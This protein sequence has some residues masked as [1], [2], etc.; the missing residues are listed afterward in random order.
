MEMYSNPFI[1][2]C[3]AIL[4]LV[5]PLMSFAQTAQQSP[6]P[7]QQKYP[8]PFSKSINQ[9]DRDLKVCK[10][11]YLSFKKSREVSYLK[12]AETYC[13][14]AIKMLKATQAVYPNTTRFFYK[15]K[16][17]RLTACKFF[18]ELQETAS[19]LDPLHHIKDVADNGCSF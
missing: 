5:F 3:L 13:S 8:V 9:S 6:L 1:Y 16:N 17:K 2:F 10:T 11:Y 14:N 7:S 19:R 18:K 15:A 12:L 4:C